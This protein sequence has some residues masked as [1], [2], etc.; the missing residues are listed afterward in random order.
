M[1]LPSFC[2]RNVGPLIPT[3]VPENKQT[4][5]GVNTIPEEK[6]RTGVA[7]ACCWLMTVPSFCVRNVGQLMPILVLSENRQTQG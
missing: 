4:N 3:L 5:T 2:V 1:I 6:V 7:K